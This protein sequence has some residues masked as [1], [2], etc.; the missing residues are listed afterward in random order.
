MFLPAFMDSMYGF[1]V[2]GCRHFEGS[3]RKV[4]KCDWRAVQGIDG[5][6]LKS[7]MCVMGIC[8]G[9]K[10]MLLVGVMEPMLMWGGFYEE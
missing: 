6:Y 9:V 8:V 10:E 4:E 7:T 5:E 3:A 1:P 2:E